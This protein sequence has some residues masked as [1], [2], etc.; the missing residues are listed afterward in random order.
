MCGA[1]TGHICVR[2]HTR[3]LGGWGALKNVSFIA[4]TRSEQRPLWWLWVG[5]GPLYIEI[6][7][8][9]HNGNIRSL[10]ESFPFIFVM[11]E[12]FDLPDSFGYLSFSN[13]I[14]FEMETYFKKG[15]KGEIR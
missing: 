5:T 12:S 1:I 13:P 15:I 2:W 7:G 10:N 8:D 6:R 4:I 14:E 11:L 9:L 3:P